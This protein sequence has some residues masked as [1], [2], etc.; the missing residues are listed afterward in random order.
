MSPHFSAQSSPSLKPRLK[1]STMP[2]GSDLLVISASDSASEI[3]VFCSEFEK[4]VSPSLVLE[5]GSKN[6]SLASNVQRG[7]S[8]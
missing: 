1:S 6:L 5:A 7:L 3:I 4:M 8:L 2:S